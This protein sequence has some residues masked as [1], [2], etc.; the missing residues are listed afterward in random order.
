MGF[1]RLKLIKIFFMSLLLF[2]N[3]FHSIS[4]DDDSTNELSIQRESDDDTE[5]H[6]NFG[7][8][9]PQDITINLDG[10]K[11]EDIT[12]KSKVDLLSGVFKKNIEKLKDKNK[13]L[14]I[15]FLVDASSSVGKANF[16]SELKFVKKLLSDFPVSYEYTRVSIV[17][18]SSQGKIIRH[19]DQ[20]SKPSQVNDKC[21]L[22]NHELN[23]IEFTGGGTHTFG[24]FEESQDIFKHAR[25]GS[26][27]LI[28]LVT[29]GY[30]NGRDP[31]PL[32]DE[33]KK[34]NV[35]IYTIGIQS[36]NYAEL[37]SISS[38]PGELHSYLLDSFGQFESLAR[39]ALHAGTYEIL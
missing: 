26:K 6:L 10:N 32:A 37:Y 35:T 12:T 9:Q 19:V 23:K 17:T 4:L 18:F 28:F 31:I 34:D 36:G 8:Y 7:E 30:S 11:L 38:S 3:I 13:K 5:M 29:D 22:L 33:L 16:E 20:I 1:R 2:T 39:K 27:K 25:F 14:D 15:V 21:S 24:A